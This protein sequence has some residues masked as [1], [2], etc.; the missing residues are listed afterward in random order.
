MFRPLLVIFR[1][2]T[3]LFQEATLPTTD[4]LFCVI[5]LIFICL[6]NSAVVCLMCVCELSRQTTAEFA[7]HIKIGPLTQ[8][9]GSVVGRVAS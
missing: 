9:N 8:N 3:Q 6:A 1:R 2:T 4:P 5:G 7:K